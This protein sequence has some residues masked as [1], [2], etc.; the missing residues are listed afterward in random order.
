MKQKVIVFKL[1]KLDRFLNDPKQVLNSQGVVEWDT[2]VECP[3]LVEAALQKNSAALQSLFAD[4][5]RYLCCASRPRAVRALLDFAAIEFRQFDIVWIEM[6][7]DEELLRGE[8]GAPWY[9]VIDRDKCS[10][11]GVCNDYC[12]FSVYRLESASDSE[13]SVCVVNPLNCKPGCPACARL[14]KTGALIFPFHPEQR[15]NGRLAEKDVSLA[16]E[17]M[18]AFEADPMKVLAERR[19]KRRLLDERKIAEDERAHYLEAS[20]KEMEGK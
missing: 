8:T 14:C 6:E 20:D 10:A 5:C 18:K 3:D 1:G 7:Y 19:L 15:L 9:P 17:L 12:L 13:R 4:E 11:C 16:D 2:F